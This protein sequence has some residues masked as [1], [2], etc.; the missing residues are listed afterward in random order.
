MI[1]STQIQGVID[2]LHLYII[3]PSLVCYPL[4]GTDIVSGPL[5]RHLACSVHTHTHTTHHTPRLSVPQ[6]AILFTH[7]DLIV[8][9]HCQCIRLVWLVTCEPVN[10]LQ[11]EQ[12]PKNICV[13][14]QSIEGKICNTTFYRGLSVDFGVEWVSQLFHI[15]QVLGSDLSP[16]TGYWKSSD[17]LRFHKPPPPPSP[18]KMPGRDLKW[19]HCHFLPH[20]VHFIIK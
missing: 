10:V 17:F 19:G 11:L 3:Q 15:L 16:E 6:N 13:I 4:R 7:L 14:V 9:P 1:C 2:L 20:P 18:S 8:L 12:W 5:P